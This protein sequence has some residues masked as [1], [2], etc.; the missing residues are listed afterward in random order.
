MPARALGT[1]LIA[2]T[3]L[4]PCAG[5]AGSPYTARARASAAGAPAP[6]AAELRFVADMGV[7]YGVF[8][9]W[10]L[11]PYRRGYFAAQPAR[12]AH[13]AAA[14]AALRQTAPSLAGA[15]MLARTDPRLQ[16]LLPLVGAMANGFNAVAATLQSGTISAIGMRGTIGLTMATEGLQH[17]LGL[18]VPETNPVPGSAF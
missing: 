4:V 13:L 12:Q 8:R 11:L 10:A 3:V 5:L 9:H 1:L 14:G 2:A 18:P 6:T 7:A 15:L 17:T 16:P